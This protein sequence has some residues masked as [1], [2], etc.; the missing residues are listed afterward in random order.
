MHIFFLFLLCLRYCVLR[1]LSISHCLDI[2]L[3]YY[4]SDLELLFYCRLFRLFITVLEAP[5]SQG[6]LIIELLNIDFAFGSKFLI[7]RL[8]LSIAFMLRFGSRFGLLFLV[9]ILIIILSID[10]E[11]YFDYYCSYLGYYFDY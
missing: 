3:A 5:V 8:F 7:C 6:Y 4:L 11:Y 10:F 2:V 9:I 1:W